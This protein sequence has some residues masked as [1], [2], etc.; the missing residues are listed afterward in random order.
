M[1]SH[2]PWR[3]AFAKGGS[4]LQR[5][6]I[7]GVGID[8]VSRKEALQIICN[9]IERG[10]AVRAA[11]LP[12]DEPAH[13]VT[14]NSEIVM[15]ANAQPHL[16][17][18]INS[19]NLVVADGSG[20]VWAAR[21]LGQPLPERVAGI[22]LMGETLRVCAERG[23]RPFFLG[24]APSVA[25]AAIATWQNRLPQLEVAGWEHGY[26]PNEQTPSVLEKVRESEAD[27]LLVALG[28]PRQEYWIDTYRN[29][30]AV[31]L[32]VGVGGSFDVWAGRVT[33]APRWMCELGCEWAY[34]LLREPTRAWR[35]SALPRFALRVIWTK[36][37]GDYKKGA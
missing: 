17:R 6:N 21:K 8:Q 14:V 13:V 34:R 11:G 15:A 35:M 32:V 26:F 19:A 18:I 30:L 28:A 24:A 36:W 22:D 9:Y 33:R 10:R 37:R 20:V 23:W 31:P 25:E 27:L 5:V 7:L 12:L 2:R 3:L 29:Q 1:I 4:R 16:H